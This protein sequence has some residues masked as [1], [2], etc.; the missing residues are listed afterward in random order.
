MRIG[1]RWRCKDG[2]FDGDV[3][4]DRLNE[5]ERLQEVLH[6]IDTALQTCEGD[7][8]WETDVYLYL[9]DMF[10][11]YVESV[12]VCVTG[13]PGDRI[14]HK[15][16]KQHTTKVHKKR[17]VDKHVW[18]D[19]ECKDSA[20]RMHD[21]IKT[22]NYADQRKRHNEYRAICRRK[23][24]EWLESRNNE[25]E[26]VLHLDK[27]D[28]WSMVDRLTGFT[29]F[30]TPLV[31]A[32]KLRAH[33]SKAFNINE[34]AAEMLEQPVPPCKP[35]KPFDLANPYVIKEEIELILKK[36]KRGK[37]AG[38][39]GMPSDTLCDLRSI[40]VFVDS[41]YKLVNVMIHLGFWP[42]VWNQ[43]LIAPLLKHGKDPLEASSYRPIH[44]ICVL[45][46]VVSRIV[47][48]RLY[49]IV[50]S[51]E[52]QMA[53]IRSHGTRDNVFV[54]NT[55]VDKYKGAGI[56]LVFVDFTA[57]FDT[58]D[59]KL[60]LEKLRAKGALDE[61]FLHLLSVML[62]GVTASV[63]SSV[64]KWFNEGLGVKQG[65]PSGP[66]MFVTFIHDLPEHVCPDD[67]LSREFCVFLVNQLIRCLLW[68][69]DLVL[70]SLN[71]A[72]TQ[73]QIN[74]LKAYCVANKL[75]VNESKTKVMYINTRREA[76]GSVKHVFV[77]GSKELENVASFKYVGV[78]FDDMGTCDFH[79]KELTAKCSRSMCMSKVRRM[80]IKCPP[81]LR[82]TL[83]KS[84]VQ[85]ILTYACEVIPYQ[86]K[87]IHSMNSI[88]CKYAR[89][90]TGLPSHACSNS[91]MRE[92]GLR[93][94]QY[95]Y[96]QARMNY[97]L[98][99]QSRSG[100][101]V[102]RLA[103]ADLYSRAS[104]SAYL[105]WYKGIDN[106]FSK[107]SCTQLITNANGS[108]SSITTSKSVL[109]KLVHNLWLNEGGSSLVGIETCNQFTTHLRGV[110][111]ED[112]CVN[113]NIGIRMNVLASPAGKIALHTQ[114]VDMCKYGGKGCMHLHT[115]RIRTYEREALS[116]FRV[117]VAPCYIKRPEGA[118]ELNSNRLKRTCTYCKHIHGVSHIN[119]VFHVLFVCPLV[120]SE[121]VRMWNALAHEGSCNEW[122]ITESISE[123]GISLLCPQSVAVA[124]IV[125]RF[126]SEYLAASEFYELARCGGNID[127]YM[128]RWIGCKQHVADDLRARLR[129]I[130][131]R[132][133][134]HRLTPLPECNVTL[135]WISKLTRD[136][137]QSAF[138]PIRAWLPPGW[139]VH[140]ENV[141]KSTPRSIALF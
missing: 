113:E 101:H 47:E 136:N 25:I 78:W 9:N 141:H 34:A 104:T 33:Y 123:L 129:I 121:R 56:Y 55:I 36:L 132:Y 46:K 120:S 84:Y 118:T 15:D 102:T 64:L 69:D 126:L 115:L 114:V 97:Y 125:G 86:R 30:Q 32:E 29:S 1:K 31:S 135:S 87:H 74:A 95:D 68:A 70:F 2:L 20:R 53:Y 76:T 10:D 27:R 62:T 43:V 18:Y 50:G 112:V 88:I 40:P 122:S 8:L 37:A 24:V 17:K 35:S 49:E 81:R 130:L 110:R 111:S 65:D 45:A 13:E 98:L 134:A 63:K 80:S 39:D 94:I 52:G 61:T 6:K 57:A 28:L 75:C 96:L 42:K 77:Y 73:Q 51:P 4:C 128:P 103:L 92:A 116:L 5:S 90:A 79:V 12:R 22:G 131:H 100:T 124:C 16:R 139:A 41:L 99:L 106:A 89:W 117:G 105:R 83:F 14:L 109:K 137:I 127:T 59:R 91:V 26:R 21:S 23:R 19:K 11:E 48:R 108:P 140:L 82:A 38:I 3:V 138:K 67:P 119:D 58:I 7:A 107:L 85:P 60:L 72:H 93:P 71:A 54:L 133:D 44:L 66:R